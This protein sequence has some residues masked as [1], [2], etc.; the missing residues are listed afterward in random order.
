MNVAG[1]NNFVVSP[2]IEVIVEVD[3]HEDKLTQ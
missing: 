2:Y 3:I 1:T